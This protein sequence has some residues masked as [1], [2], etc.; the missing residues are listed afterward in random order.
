MQALTELLPVVAFFATYTLTKNMF[1]A[2]G[3]LLA[4]TV[5]QVG[6]QWVRTRSVSRMALISAGLALVFGGITIVLHDALYIM[7][8]PTLLWALFALAF[9]ASQLFTN[10]P[11]LQ[12][13]MESQV[14]ADAR[15]WKIANALWAAF[16]LALALVNY[17]FV[18]AYSH[19]P[20]GSED[21]K[22]WESA[23]ATWK[24]SSIGVILLFALVQGWWLVSR[25][26]L[27]ANDAA[28]PKPSSDTPADSASARDP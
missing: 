15:T 25:G 21:Q 14:T 12:R 13:F 5:V 22:G 20:A 26:E 1:V 10:R 2:T 4:A 8:K 23:W 11:L 7:W 28:A 16:F 9:V 19:A 17:V 3:V 6:V 24:L 18:Y 27:V